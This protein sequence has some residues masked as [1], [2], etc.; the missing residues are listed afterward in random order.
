MST[1][2]VVIATFNRVALLRQ[3][4]ESLRRQGYGRG[5][6]VIVVDNAS[7]D[8]TAH[9]VQDLSRAFPVPLMLLREPSPGKTPALMRGLAAA[10]GEILALTDDDVLAAEDWIET[11]RDVFRDPSIALVG[12]RVEPRWER[13][14]PP[15]LRIERNGRYTRMSAPLALLHYGRDAQP[16]GARTAVGANMAVR[17]DVLRSVGGMTPHLGRQ[18]GTLMGGEDHDLCQ[19]AVAAGYRCE[20]RPE[21]RVRHWVP[22]ERTR[23]SYYVRWFFWCGITHAAVE[24]QHSGAGGHRSAGSALYWTRQSIMAGAFTLASGVAGRMAAASEH[25]TDAAFALGQLAHRVRTRQRGDAQQR[26]TLAALEGSNVAPR[27]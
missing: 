16:L 6:E 13:P 24:Q 19:R 1:I 20:Y 18:R 23:L 8:G 21:L 2:S 10:R 15:W 27:E 26:A 14:A 25:A 5:D 9:V 4:L 11:I 3:T 7:S 22:A 12:G 17:A